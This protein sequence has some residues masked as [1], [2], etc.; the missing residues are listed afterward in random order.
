M[1][2][3]SRAGVIDRALEGNRFAARAEAQQ[4]AL[5]TEHRWRILEFEAKIG[6]GHLKFGQL[7]GA[8]GSQRLPR[9]I[10]VERAKHLLLT[11]RLVDGAEAERIGLVAEAVPAA[12]LEAHVDTLVESLLAHG[13]A[14]VEGMKRL[15][16]RGMAGTLAEGLRMEIDHVHR[17]ATTHPDA[18]EGLLAFRDKRRPRFGA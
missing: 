4:M 11:G 9:A 8:G 2:F 10:G 18:T 7:P 12:E 16:N 1:L 3:R 13:R 15:V 14:G 5:E 6:D 17:Y